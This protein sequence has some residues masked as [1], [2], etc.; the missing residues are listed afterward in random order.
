VIDDTYVFNRTS[1]LPGSLA[2]RTEDGHMQA[3]LAGLQP[4]PLLS[5][6]DEAGLNALLDSE[7]V[8][9]WLKDHL[10]D[11]TQHHDL[12]DRDSWSELSVTDEAGNVLE[13][14]YQRWVQ[15]LQHEA[16]D[17]LVSDKEQLGKDLR[18]V[19]G[20]LYEFAENLLPFRLEAAS[21][22]A[23]TLG[24]LLGRDGGSG[25]AGRLAMETA[26]LRIFAY[27]GSSAAMAVAAKRPL[28][29]SPLPR[30]VRS[31]AAVAR[32]TGIGLRQRRILGPGRRAARRPAAS[33]EHPGKRSV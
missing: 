24:P 18:T 21:V 4:S 14:C 30:V 20:G 26:L 33:H 28:L 23:R 11:A 22:L 3:Y 1:V 17:R 19:L 9:G 29:A 25:S 12:D 2:V 15:H 32:R 7:R 16:D 10:P 6:D 27:A 13:G 5:A 8:R 31:G